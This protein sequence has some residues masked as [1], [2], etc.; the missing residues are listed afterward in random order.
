MALW[1]PIPVGVPL[2]EY[3]SYAP[4]IWRFLSEGADADV[5]ARELARWRTG[6]I[7]MGADEDRDRRTAQ[8]LKDWWYWRF[9]YP[10]DVETS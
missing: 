7:G 5:I 2:D 8:R 3:E 6:H 9:E 10:E 4:G 1:E